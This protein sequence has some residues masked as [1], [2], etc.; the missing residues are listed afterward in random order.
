MEFVV[1]D[2]TR[3][4]F[5]A[6]TL[7]SFR[8]FFWSAHCSLSRWVSLGSAPIVCTHSRSFA[9]TGYTSAVSTNSQLFTATTLSIHLHSHRI[10]SYPLIPLPTYCPLA[11]Q[12]K[13]TLITNNCL[14]ARQHALSIHR[15][16]P[17][18]RNLDGIRARR[19][20]TLG[21]ILHLETR[22][23]PRKTPQWQAKHK[24]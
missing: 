22:K 20:K 6:Q 14:D 15:R 12:P 7:P 10:H 11:E 24:M 23:I 18:H 13:L 19:S 3:H 8:S 21:R 9:N 1:I 16:I 4:R 17:L 5:T 2:T